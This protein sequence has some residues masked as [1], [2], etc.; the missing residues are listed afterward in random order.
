MF[1]IGLVYYFGGGEKA[2]PRSAAPQ[3][4]AAAPVL[5]IVPIAAK[6]QQYCSILAVQFD[7]NGTTVQRDAEEKIEKVA[8]HAQIP[9]HHGGDRG[10]Q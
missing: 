9:R 10:S 2:A 1:S 7:I 5:V 6:T 4:V 3:P 8:I